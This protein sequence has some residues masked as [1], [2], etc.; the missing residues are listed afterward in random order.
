MWY[1]KAALVRRILV[2]LKCTRRM[3]VASGGFFV[4]HG[5]LKKIDFQYRFGLSIAY[6]NSGRARRNIAVV[7]VLLVFDKIG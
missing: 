4:L 6:R 5:L 2:S 7:Q 3:F 1:N